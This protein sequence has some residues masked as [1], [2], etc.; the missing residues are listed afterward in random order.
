VAIAEVDPFTN[1]RG[2]VNVVIIRANVVITTSLHDTS[3][4]RAGKSQESQSVDHFEKLKGFFWCL[5]EKLGK[6]KRVKILKKDEEQIVMAGP[7]D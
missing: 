3:E 7:R 1:S 6:F 2:S 4:G 5:I